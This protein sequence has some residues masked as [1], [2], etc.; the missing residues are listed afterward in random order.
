LLI[1]LFIRS[2]RATLRYPTID[3]HAHVISTATVRYPNAPLGGLKSDW[4]RE[5]PVNV[6]QM[7]AAMN[8]AGI[9]ES[10]L[11]QA[12]TCYSHDNSYVADAVAAH[13]DRFAGVFSVNVLAPDAP[14]KIRKR[15]RTNGATWWTI[16]LI[17]CWTN[18]D[19]LDAPAGKAVGHPFTNRSVIDGAG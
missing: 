2:P 15:Q 18:L 17:F 10:A 9:A 4:S 14:E 13:P 3:I 8:E 19:S 6:E 7:I 16:W 1:P 5:R 12:S 11:V